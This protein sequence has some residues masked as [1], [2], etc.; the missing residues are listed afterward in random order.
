[1][2]NVL[3]STEIYD[4]LK[5]NTVTSGELPIGIVM[6]KITNIDNKI[7]LFGK[8]KLSSDWDCDW[9]WGWEM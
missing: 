4:G 1:M 3:V 5:W 9:D 2:K 7:L 6:S 8:M